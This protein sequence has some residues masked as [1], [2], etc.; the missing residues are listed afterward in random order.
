MAVF[1]NQ[2]TNHSMELILF[3]V[4]RTD[5]FVAPPLT[6]HRDGAFVDIR[7]QPPWRWLAESVA[8]AQHSGSALLLNHDARVADPRRIDALERP[9]VPHVDRLCPPPDNLEFDPFGS[10]VAPDR[11][12][13]DGDPDVYVST[14]HDYQARFRND[15]T[16][17]FRYETT[18]IAPPTGLR[19]SGTGWRGDFDG[20]DDLDLV[21]P[22]ID[23]NDSNIVCTYTNTIQSSAS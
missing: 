4:R 6:Q 20:D 21:V 14:Q 23:A 15:G 13:R 9:R 11:D 1:E 2:A 19:V 3:H 5:R 8:A 7:G 12:D 17:A 22:L 18:P 10:R 16:G